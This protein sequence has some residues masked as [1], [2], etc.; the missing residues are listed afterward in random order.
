MYLGFDVS[1][2]KIGIAALDT[3]DDIVYLNV[4][5]FDK[6]LELEERAIVFAQYLKEG[7][8][9]FLQAPSVVFIEKPLV[10][11]AAA[12]S[13]MTIAT[14]I[15]FNGMISFILA[16]HFGFLSLP[17]A[18]NSARARVG[19]KLERGA[20]RKKYSERKAKIIDW[21]V[22]KY[23]AT[24]TPF[25]YEL[26]RFGNPSPGVDDLADAIVLVLGGKRVHSI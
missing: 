13:A 9:D 12:S 2:T 4:L 10:M 18:A 17:V 14:L 20:A 24:Q 11:M 7:L 15:R 26:T 23:Q 25:V 21:V 8:P 1:S 16:Q 5:E 22:E 3:N 6:T 19:I